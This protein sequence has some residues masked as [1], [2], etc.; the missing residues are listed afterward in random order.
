MI[1]MIGERIEPRIAC[2]CAADLLVSCLSSPSLF[3]AYHILHQQTVCCV[4]LLRGQV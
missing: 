2:S 3:E 1:A 4:F